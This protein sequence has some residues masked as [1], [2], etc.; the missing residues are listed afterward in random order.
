M[1]FD[2]FGF[3][4]YEGKDCLRVIYV[5]FYGFFNKYKVECYENEC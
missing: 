5:K 2:L 3:F 1:K 4:Y